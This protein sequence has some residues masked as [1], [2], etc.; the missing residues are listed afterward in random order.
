MEAPFIFPEGD[1]A[2]GSVARTRGADASRNRLATAGRFPDVR[3]SALYAPA[4]IGAR[5]CI[6]LWMLAASH[7]LGALGCSGA[8]T[9]GEAPSAETPSEPAPP[10]SCEASADAPE[11]LP[12]VT[13]EHRTAAYWIAR[14]AELE[15]GADDALM[16]PEEIAA[17]DAAVTRA[18]SDLPFSYASLAHPPA[19]ALVRREIDERLAFVRERFENG[20]YVDA[21][22]GQP[23]AELQAR[24]APLR[25]L[26][27]AVELRV[28]TTRLA[29]RCAPLPEPFYTV[30][31]DA[32]FDRN[33]CS[34]VEA[35]ELVQVLARWPGEPAMWLVRT[36]YALGWIAEHDALSPPIPAADVARWALAPRARAR[37]E[38]ELASDDGAAGVEIGD[39]VLVPFVEG[40]ALF[41]TREG[42][43]RSA[44]LTPGVLEPSRRALTRRAFLTEVFRHLGEPYGWGGREG[45][46]DC[47]ELTMDVLS[48]FGLELPR[49]S[50]R[51]AEV[52]SFAID[53]PADLSE[54][55][56]LSIL[57]AAV[58]RGVVLLQFPGHIMAYLGRDAA[59]TPMAIHAFAEYVRPC[60]GGGETLVRTARVDVSDLE[61]GRGSSRRAFVE[62]ITR[63]V[64]FGRSPGPEL[65]GAATLRPASPVEVPRADACRD[66]LHARVF[67]SPAYPS[68][69]QRLRFVLTST[70]EIGPLDVAIVDPRGHRVP[71]VVVHQLGG[72]PWAAWVEVPRAMAGRWTAVFG[73][74]AR[75]TAC[76]RVTVARF[77][78]DPELPPPVLDAPAPETGFVLAEP[79]RAI[80]APRWT[81]ERDVENFYATFVEQLFA[82]DEPDRT[83]RSLTELLRSREHNLLYDH[84]AQGEDELLELVPDCADLP[85]FLRAYFSWKLRLP[86]AF[87]RC[88]RGRAG[89]PPTCGEVV[90][91]EMPHAQATDVDAFRW[92]VERQLRPG[93]HSASGR[94]A[95]AD[96]ATD[97][98]PVPITR[99]ALR[100]GTVF[101]DPYGHLLVVAAWRPQPASGYGALV[102]ADAQPDGTIG[103]RTF[104]RGTFLFTPDTRDVGA[105][106]K[107]WRPVL[108]DREQDGAIVMLPNA[109]L[110][111]RSG[112]TPFSMQQ[113]RGSQDDFYDRM[114]AL[115]S[116]RPE[117]AEVAQRTLVDALYESVVRRVVSVE[118]GEEWARAH[119]GQTVPM[120]E[121]IDIFLTEG[122][123][124]DYSTPSRD[125]RLLIAIDTVMGFGDAIRR[126]PARYGVREG[127]DLDAVV[128]AVNALRDRELASRRFAYRRSDGAEQALTLADVVAR[129]EAIELAWNPNDCVELR[130]GAAEGSDEARSCRRR[131]PAEQRGR[132]A[133]MRSWFHQRMRPT[134]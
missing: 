133:T 113:Y 64:V 127:D 109:E 77:P 106:F 134:R 9:R 38:V 96:D 16:T 22:G 67:H 92:F 44:L 117:S 47:S 37:A 73:D 110:D 7:A 8:E 20:T 99:D 69:G 27:L 21:S 93:V 14:A 115:V 90:T 42:L 50:A 57:D 54:S 51:Q 128:R 3:R 95:P 97:L 45:G 132:M 53:V 48:T 86:F 72:P 121:G 26:T 123:W 131:A 46:L 39:D 60:E 17:H 23:P 107:A 34:T 30:P 84:L 52:G 80:W 75:I 104:W 18:G 36:R 40:R 89:Q 63:V 68:A 101:A 78:R 25:E 66:D 108:V 43:H 122:P 2:R 1:K 10:V 120:P 5:R 103:R 13:P 49:H 105:G 94:T 28:A 24:V 88:S 33:A 130:W 4:V 61:L 32:A 111:A 126:A 82:Y 56:R 91:I 112:F 85:Y 74:G 124:E 79:Y 81:W 116:P 70:R 29:L 76:E 11:L 100:P 58:E 15:G 102:G 6:A 71:S 129:A 83:W 55:S 41:A 98:Y 35:Q 12:N 62:R 31:T 125:M 65:A 59:G 114:E 118:N 119:P 19:E 87:H